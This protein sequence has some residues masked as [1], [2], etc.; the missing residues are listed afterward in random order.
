MQRTEEWYAARRGRLT[1]SNLGAAL[2][3]VSYTSRAEALRRALGTDSFTGNVATQWGETNEDTA[4]AAYT[5]LTGNAVKATGLHMHP[6]H[7]WLGGSPDGFV[8]TRGLV[9]V[10]CPYY[11]KRGGRV[12]QTV[13]AHYYTQVNALLEICD[14]DWC[15]Y[16]CWAPEGFAVHRVSR[17]SATFQY[18]LPFYKE[19]YGAIERRDTLPPPL[20]Q[21]QQIADALQAAIARNVSTHFWRGVA[22]YSETTDEMQYGDAAPDPLAKQQCIADRPRRSRSYSNYEAAAA[23]EM[24]GA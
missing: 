17:D 5:A 13:P 9:E 16:V 6:E 18:L 12:H 21:K 1:A 11:H 3:Q 14:R 19:F 24:A 2:G 10:K 7:A 8:G 4:I 15:D 23:G 22:R 20:P